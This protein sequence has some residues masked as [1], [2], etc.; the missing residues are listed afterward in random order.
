MIIHGFKQELFFFFFLIFLHFLKNKYFIVGSSCF[1]W[2]CAWGHSDTL[3]LHY[4]PRKGT[5]LR[6]K[7]DLRERE[8]EV[9]LGG[10]LRGRRGQRAQAPWTGEWWRFSRVGRSCRASLKYLGSRKP[11]AF[12][13]VRIT[14]LAERKKGIPSADKARGVTSALSESPGKS[15]L[16]PGS[17]AKARGPS[18]N[19]ATSQFGRMPVETIGAGA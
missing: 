15:L 17:P 8:T 1:L 2:S 18:M 9:S 12:P 13:G 14:P 5:F 11:S 19:T 3:S 4:Q 7:Q 16:C 6:E 10:E